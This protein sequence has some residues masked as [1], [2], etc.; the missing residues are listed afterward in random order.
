MGMTSEASWRDLVAHIAADKT[1]GASALAR[2]TVRALMTFTHQAAPYDLATLRISLQEIARCI[3]AGQPSMAPLLRILNDA[4]AV[5]ARAASPG[6]AL[7]GL[8][9]VC[10]AY[11]S[12]L[13]LATERIA[14]HARPVI[15]AAARVVTISHS[16]VVAQSLAEA[17]QQGAALHVVCLE[18]RPRC[19]GRGLASYLAQCGLEVEIA[20]DAAAYEVL[21]DADLWLA[22]ADSLTECGVVNKVGTALL[23]VA[24]RERGIPGYILCDRSKVWPSDL[25]SPPVVAQE[26]DEVWAD[27]P[28]GVA[29]RNRYFDLTPWRLIAAVVDDEGLH[30]PE[31]IIQACRAVKVDSEIAAIITA[32]R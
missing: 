21:E 13:A 18:S 11:E 12:A 4:A 26:A 2:D 7:N 6:E 8:Q 31:Q 9:R 32:M 1:S 30:T 25:G 17:H 22:G 14:E 19:E 15:G 5:C 28:L 24:A 27:A 20:V 29:V 23:A 3:L 10:R 16:S